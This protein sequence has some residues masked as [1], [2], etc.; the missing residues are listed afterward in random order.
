[1]RYLDEQDLS[2][3]ITIIQSYDYGGEMPP[4]YGSEVDGIDE[5]LALFGNGVSHHFSPLKKGG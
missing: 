3:I 1:M 2:E 4:D 5:V